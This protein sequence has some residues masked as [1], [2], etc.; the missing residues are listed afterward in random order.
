MVSKVLRMGESSTGNE[1]SAWFSLLASEKKVLKA[2]ALDVSTIKIFPSEDKMG[3]MDVFIVLKQD[4]TSLKKEFWLILA[5]SF[6]Y[7][8]LLYSFLQRATSRK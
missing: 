4:F 2:L 5:S 3:G 1:L 7:I 6:S 8:L